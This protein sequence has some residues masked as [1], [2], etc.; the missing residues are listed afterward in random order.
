M[1]SIIPR[2][3]IKHLEWNPSAP[4]T[5]SNSGSQSI[6]QPAK[7]KT[8]TQVNLDGNFSK[9]IQVGINGIKCNPVVISPFELAGHG[10]LNY[11][12]AHI[13]LAESG[14]Y[15]PTPKIFMAHFNNV[16]EAKKGDRKLLYA[17]GTEVSDDVVKDMYLHYTKDHKVIYKKGQAGVWTWLN[18]KFVNGTG[19]KK[20]DLE[21][22][23]GVSGKKLESTREKLEDCVWENTLVD[24]DVNSQGLAKSKS[25]DED[26]AQGKNIYFWKPVKNAVAWFNADSDRAD[27]DCD[28]V[29]S[30]SDSSLGVFG[31]AEGALAKNLGGSS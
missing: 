30:Y 12:N 7:P 20:M 2:E 6:P 23:I 29:P 26:Y 5:Q 22:V 18:A 17:D 10:G 19:F 3:L 31:C 9:Y 4:K 8:T 25:S 28:W 13:K 14:L 15:M 21:T 16:V 27:L 1:S 24:L 11:E